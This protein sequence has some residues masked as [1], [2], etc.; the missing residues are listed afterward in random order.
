MTP[1]RIL[2]IE[3]NLGDARLIETY[4]DRCQN[5]YNVEHVKNLAEGINRLKGNTYDAVLSD[6]GLPDSDGI[7]SIYKI[8][9]TAPNVPLV[10]L[11]GN[12]DQNLAVMAVREGAQEYLLK[13]RINAG[14]LDRVLAG[15]FHRP[16]QPDRRTP[17]DGLPRPAHRPAQPDDVPAHAATRH[18]AGHP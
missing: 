9:D 2:L 3:D 6:L 8:R 16:P 15:L 4:L 17:A 11:T 7:L 14:V 10:V 13:D 1:T 18:A 12:N 5:G